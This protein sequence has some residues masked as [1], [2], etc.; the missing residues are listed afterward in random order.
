[1]YISDGYTNTMDS[2]ISQYWRLTYKNEHST[3]DQ[4]TIR[5]TLNG[6]VERIYQ[7]TIRNLIV[8]VLSLREPLDLTSRLTYHLIHNLIGRE[9]ISKD[10]FNIIHASIMIHEP[11]YPSLVN[12]GNS[13]NLNDWRGRLISKYYIGTRQCH[14]ITFPDNEVEER[15]RSLESALR[16]NDWKRVTIKSSDSVS[17]IMD[18]LPELGFSRSGLIITIDNSLHMTP[19]LRTILE[20]CIARY[21]WIC[22]MSRPSLIDGIDFPPTWHVKVLHQQVI[23][24]AIDSTSD[25]VISTHPMTTNPPIDVTEINT[26]SPNLEGVVVDLSQDA[27]SEHLIRNCQD[28]IELCERKIVIINSNIPT[29]RTLDSQLPEK[30]GMIEQLEKYKK[31][32]VVLQRLILDLQ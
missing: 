18:K 12:Y 28:H 5:S 14:W 25:V 23:T 2:T 20:E 4:S 3:V 26:I 24:D 8:Y 11:I 16:Y 17:A 27:V 1:M 30:L 21:T 13:Y 10:T 6:M 31:E 19:W 22:V 7:Y 29:L 32:I 15:S 9:A